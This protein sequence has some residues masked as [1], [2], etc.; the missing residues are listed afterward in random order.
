MRILLTNDDGIHAEG[1]GELR[2]VLETDH[3]VIAVAPGSF[4]SGSGHAITFTSPLRVDE[5]P[6]GN[7]TRAYSVDGTPA[8]CVKIAVRELLKD[9]PV[10][11][12]VSGLNHGHNAGINVFYSGTIAAAVEGRILGFP[13]IALSVARGDA[14][15][16]P[17]A[18]RIAKKIIGQWITDGPVAGSLLSVNIPNR[19]PQEIAG[20]RVTRQNLSPFRTEGFERRTDPWGRD[21]FWIKGGVEVDGDNADEDTRALSEGYISI[22][23]LKL[24]MTD[25]AAFDPLPRWTL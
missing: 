8:D 10:D 9:T 25:P 21:Y 17:E 11:L 14:I 7:G 6:L 3:E 22:T 13:S 20:I 19:K 18:A 12:V 2:K 4:R 16:F 5:V 23:P 1:M 24:D 15:T